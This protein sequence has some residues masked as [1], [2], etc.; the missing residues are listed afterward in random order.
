MALRRCQKSFEW[1]RVVRSAS[2]TLNWAAFK[3]CWRG[4]I[5]VLR[6]AAYLGDFTET[7]ANLSWSQSVQTCQEDCYL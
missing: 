4:K 7:S 2:F 1:D 3:G 5:D 6:L